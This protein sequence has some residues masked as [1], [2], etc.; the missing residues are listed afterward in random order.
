MS[1]SELPALSGLL[2]TFIKIVCLD[3]KFMCAAFRTV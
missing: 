1:G 2:R 3:I